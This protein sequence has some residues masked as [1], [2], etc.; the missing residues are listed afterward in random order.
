MIEVCLNGGDALELD[1][2]FPPQ[3]D[4]AV[5]ELLETMILRDDFLLIERSSADGPGRTLT[6]P[7]S[8]E[9]RSG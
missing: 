6:P 2:E 7:N 1:L 9:L 3:L 8:H 4:D 5:L